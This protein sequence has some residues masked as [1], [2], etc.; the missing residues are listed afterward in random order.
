MSEKRFCDRCGASIASKE[1]AHRGIYKKVVR[2][3][4]TFWQIGSEK[5]HWFDLC[6]KCFEGFTRWIEEG[7]SDADR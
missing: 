2:G 5:E 7:R 1:E 3:H 6:D 4:V